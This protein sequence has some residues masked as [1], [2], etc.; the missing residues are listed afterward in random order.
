M[1]NRKTRKWWIS[2][3]NDVIPLTTQ[4]YEFF[5]PLIVSEKYCV[6][7]RDAENTR[8]D[9]L[10]VG[11]VRVNYE[12]NGGHLTIETMR[13]DRTLRKV[14][15]KFILDNAESIDV[16]HL[17]LLNRD[18]QL[19]QLGCAPLLQMRLYETPINRLTL[20]LLN[21]LRVTRL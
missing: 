19:L 15:D 7:F 6:P 14:V 10:R 5:Q 2:P 3:E 9:A 4:H 17:H 8:L 11:F 18:G 13:W 1:M 16:A 20:G 21:N 12:I